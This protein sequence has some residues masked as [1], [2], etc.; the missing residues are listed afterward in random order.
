MCG[1]AESPFPLAAEDPNEET[2]EDEAE[3][4]EDWGAE[5]AM[6]FNKFQPE[7]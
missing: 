1:A 6:W 2:E 3:D 5:K 4:A 7:K